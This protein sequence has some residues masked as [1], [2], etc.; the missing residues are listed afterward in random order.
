MGYGPRDR[1]VQ[2]FVNTKVDEIENEVRTEVSSH[3][4]WIISALLSSGRINGNSTSIL[5][6]IENETI[7]ILREHWVK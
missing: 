3:M 5:Q 2:R 7:K 1:D 4:A 6:R